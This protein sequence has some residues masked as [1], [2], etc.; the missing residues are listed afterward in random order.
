MAVRSL[1]L[2]KNKS[3]LIA[4]FGA[5]AK[6]TGKSEVQVA[7]LTDRIQK[8]TN[9]L[10]TNKKDFSTQRGLLKLVGQRRCLLD[11]MKQAEPSRYMKLLSDLELRK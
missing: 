4:K 6:D 9:H 1:S 5:S 7:L 8:L 2:K 3:D 11:Y 10:K